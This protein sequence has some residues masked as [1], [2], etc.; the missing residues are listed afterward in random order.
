MSP[1]RAGG[2]KRAEVLNHVVGVLIER[3]YDRTRFTDVAK[4][5]GVAVSTLQFY[6]GSRDDMLVEALHFSCAREV[7]RLAA[8]KPDAPPWERLVALVDYSL[9]PADEG[10]WRVLYEFW[11]ASMHDEELRVHSEKLQ[12][13]WSRPFV[14]TITKGVELGDFTVGDIGNMVT[15]VVGITDGLMLPQVLKHEYYD[16][17]GMRKLTLD[18]L[19]KA[20]GV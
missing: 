10:I 18:I 19:A 4:V 20:L 14:D 17:E 11:Y 6:F 5:A 13:D 9:D 16:V 2:D 1:R 7:D 3:G 8:I 12:R 15:F